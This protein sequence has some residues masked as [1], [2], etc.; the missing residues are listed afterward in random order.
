MKGVALVSVR[1]APISE[2][3][4]LGWHRPGDVLEAAIIDVFVCCSKDNA[5]NIERYKPIRIDE[6]ILL[7]PATAR[8]IYNKTIT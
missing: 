4:R 8:L 3:C 1:S 5:R 7:L 6:Y 2:D